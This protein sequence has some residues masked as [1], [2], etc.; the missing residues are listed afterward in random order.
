MSFWDLERI[1]ANDSIVWKV[2]V[3]ELRRG[4]VNFQVKLTVWIDSFNEWIDSDHIRQNWKRGEC[5]EEWYVSIKIWINSKYPEWKLIR[6]IFIMNRFRLSQRV[7][8]NDPDIYDTINSWIDS[9][10]CDTI[11][12]KLESN[13]LCFKSLWIDTTKEDTPFLRHMMHKFTRNEVNHFVHECL[14]C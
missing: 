1:V 4:S 3:W 9:I 13:M 8:W 10:F 7:W 5:K 14:S 2:W 11:H 6:F 12:M